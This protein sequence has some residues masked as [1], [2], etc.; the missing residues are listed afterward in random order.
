MS[1]LSPRVRGIRQRAFEHQRR[2]GS[3]PACTGNPG[4]VLCAASWRRVYPRVYGESPLT[5]LLVPLLAGLSPRVRGIQGQPGDGR[6]ASGS[7]P[8]CTGNPPCGSAART[9]RRVYP[10]VY[11]ESSASYSP[12]G[13][14][15]G[16]SP[17]VR[18]IRYVGVDQVDRDGSIPA[19]TG[20]PSMLSPTFPANGVYP[21]V[22]GESLLNGPLCAPQEGLSPRVR[23]IRPWES[24]GKG[25]CRSIPACTGNPETR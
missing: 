9:P 20:N 21:R 13:I 1:G 17:R 10:R 7:I 11:G 23:G 14:A 8:A 5:R 19:C 12:S 16:L 3:I 24:L 15:P 2:R 6:A 4:T 18:G 25:H 22:Y